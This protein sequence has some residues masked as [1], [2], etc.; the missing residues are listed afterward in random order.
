MEKKTEELIDETITEKT[1][2]LE[3][4][5]EL[6]EFDNKNLTDKL[7]QAETNLE[8]QKDWI[9]ELEKIDVASAQRSNY[10]K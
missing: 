3:D 1:K 4:K 6:L 8:P 7:T 2:K 10:N 5:V 9:T